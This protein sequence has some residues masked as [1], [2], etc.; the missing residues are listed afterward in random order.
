M[1]FVDRALH[2]PRDR[3][4]LCIHS[5]NRQR[6]QDSLEG[7]DRKWCPMH[8]LER[9]RFPRPVGDRR[10]EHRVVRLSIVLDTACGHLANKHDQRE[11]RVCIHSLECGFGYGTIVMCTRK[12]P[13]RVVHMRG[14]HAVYW[15]IPNT[16]SQLLSIAMF[17]TTSHDGHHEI[18]GAHDNG[19]RW[20]DE[21]LSPQCHLQHEKW[22][23]LCNHM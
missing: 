22:W 11:L 9:H 10:D 7:P 1:C 6:C 4:H 3:L 21:L 2:V 13:Q 16:L 12:A 23:C 8:K 20:R 14:R 19:H 17:F 5:G 18:H 15:K